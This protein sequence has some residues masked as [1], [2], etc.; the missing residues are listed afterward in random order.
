MSDQ[1]YYVQ[2]GQRIGPVE[3]SVLK[4]L[5]SDHQL[6]STDYVWKK[7][8]EGW[9]T[10]EQTEELATSKS[11]DGAGSDSFS[12]SLPPQ[13]STSLTI[14]LLNQ[15]EAVI[16][17]RIGKD[18]GGKACEYGPYPPKLLRKLFLE[19]RINAKTEVFATGMS[20]WIF[21][22]QIE[23]FTEFFEQTPPPI[24]EEDKRS[25]A[26][27]PFVARMF[28]ENNAKVFEGICRDVSV[29]GMQV[30]SQ[31][32]PAVAG[33]R[34]SINVHP[35][36]SDYHF[37]AS[38]VVVRRLEGNRGFSFRFENLNAQALQAIEKYLQDVG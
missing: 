2:E 36:N 12:Q 16:Y 11:E 19:N 1:W 30:L 7:G 34:I 5:I 20:E 3:E 10:V 37:V 27:K 29:G 31:D 32:F 15:D 21:L 13:M 4:Q 18:R 24:E 23:D 28:I 38:G 33:K 14:G 17:L 9:Q 22:A 35:D 8:F 25:A 6:I 26:R